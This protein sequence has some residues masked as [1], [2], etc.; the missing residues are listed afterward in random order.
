VVPRTSLTLGLAGLAAA[1]AAM[2][3]LLFPSPGA[4]PGAY[5]PNRAASERWAALAE[6]NR[7]DHLRRYTDIVRRAD[8]A[9][10]FRRARQ[11]AALP[12]SEQAQ[13][14]MLQR[15][16]DQLLADRAA[17]ERRALLLLHERARAEALYDLLEA[18]SPGSLGE[19][20]ESL[21]RPE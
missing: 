18:Q 19:L 17:S 15:R 6:T 4:P 2:T 16:L 21:R 10:I 7:A 13:L 8:A 5:L 11:F 12:A 20:R 1:G 9:E 14:R 3:V